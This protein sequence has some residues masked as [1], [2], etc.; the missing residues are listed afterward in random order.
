MP[1][2]SSK[3]D[4]SV[5]EILDSESKLK[6]YFDSN[7]IVAYLDES[8][9]FNYEAKTIIDPLK[10]EDCWFFVHHIVVGEFIHTWMMTQKSSVKGAIKAFEKFKN[11]IDH[12]LIGGHSLDARTI[13][14]NYRKHAKHR[15]FLKAHFNDFIILTEAEKIKNIKI[16]TCDWGMYNSG[17]IIFK[18]GHYFIHF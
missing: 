7:V 9:K 5:Q 14:V 3:K 16:V 1:S 8:H 6:I 15:N 11:S 13:L 10:H 4:H 18:K 12:C 17:K 2:E